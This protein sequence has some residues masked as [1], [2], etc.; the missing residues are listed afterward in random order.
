MNRP[1]ALAL[2]F[3]VLLAAPQASKSQQEDSFS[4]PSP[5]TQG[6]RKLNLWATHYY[7]YPATSVSA[8]GI[9]FKDANGNA[10]SDPVSGI[11]WC[12]AAIEGSVRVPYQGRP[13]TL[14]F[15]GTFKDQQINCSKVLSIDPDVKPWITSTGKS[16]FGPS[17]GEW[18][19]GVR[20]YKLVPFRT[21]A[22]DKNYIPYGSVIFVPRL[23]G[24]RIQTSTGQ[25]IV[26]D[27]FLFAADTGG[28][29]KENHIDVFCGPTMKNCMPT[30]VKSVSSQGFE[31]FVIDSPEISSSLR[32]LHQ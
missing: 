17:R 31:A 8:G 29:M 21:I 6:A 25:D 20:G 15:A 3:L 11:D 23:R 7:L 19:D 5:D 24:L 16:Y 22:V 9:P 2:T 4:L 18:G 12:R 28:D 32:R 27:G 1:F 30:L 10:L 13:R 14:N 26:H